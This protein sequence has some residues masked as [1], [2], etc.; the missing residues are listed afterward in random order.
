MAAGCIFHYDDDFPQGSGKGFKEAD[1]PNFTGSYYSYTKAML[2]SLLRVGL[3]LWR[4]A[5]THQLQEFA[6]G[7]LA[8]RWPAC[9]RTSLTCQL[10]PLVDG[11]PASCSTMHCTASAT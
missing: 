1:K 5:A 9:G 11:P 10:Q 6:C 8:C 3:I 7:R 2:E 4:A